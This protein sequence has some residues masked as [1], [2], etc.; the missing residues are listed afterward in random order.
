MAIVSSFSQFTLELPLISQNS[1][2][3]VDADTVLM[4]PKV[5]L[6]IF[7]P[8]PEYPHIH[9]L[10]TRDPRYINNGVFF[11]RVNPW[12]INFMSA[13]LA[14]PTFQ[15]DVPLEYKDQTAFGELLKHPAF[16]K[17]HILV[18]QRWFNAYQRE[19]DDDQQRSFQ[20]NRGDLLV[21]FP[22]VPHRDEKMRGFIDR[23]E[24][25]LPEWELEVG[26]TTLPREIEEFWVKE[27]EKIAKRREEAV[28]VDEEAEVVVKSM[29]GWLGKF[30][31][32]MDDGDLEK[33]RINIDGLKRV[34]FER[35][36]D[37][38]AVR[39]GIG[40]VHEVRLYSVLFL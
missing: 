24:R 23:A 30:W 36:D 1:T 18:P 20:I 13:I 31:G 9:L 14:F 2:S 38:E 8:P 12:S 16:A 39:D 29:E 26:N 7:L 15:P 40:R 21:H 19:L 33:I 27:H 6:D 4:N 17:N 25:H 22:G 11:I 37:V 10:C 28:K 5:P 35:E 34:L 32:D 3:W